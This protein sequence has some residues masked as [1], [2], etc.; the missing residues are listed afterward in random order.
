[1]ASPR[2]HTD[3]LEPRI[4]RFILDR[5]MALAERHNNFVSILLSRVGKDGRPGQ[6]P[7]SSQVGEVLASKLRKSDYVGGIDDEGT[8]AV[9]LINAGTEPAQLVLR[10]LRLQILLLFTKGNQGLKVKTSCAVYPSEANSLDSLLDLAFRR[11][12]ESH[13]PNA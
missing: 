13:G 2:K 9:I 6:G 7:F 3:F 5:E 4:L 10:R 1:M 11:L 12:S 8:L